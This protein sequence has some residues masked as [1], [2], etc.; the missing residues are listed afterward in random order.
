MPDGVGERGGDAVEY[1]RDGVARS[2]DWT[3]VA[4]GFDHLIEWDDTTQ[5][6]SITATNYN[7]G[8]RACW[9]EVLEDVA[10]N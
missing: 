9:N 6:G 8:V 10:C 2:F 3:Q 7:G 1:G 4:E 5:A